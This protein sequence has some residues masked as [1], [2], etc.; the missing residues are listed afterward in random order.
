MTGKDQSVG[1]PKPEPAETD[2]DQDDD[3]PLGMDE[4]V[5][6][7]GVDPAEALRAFMRTPR[8]RAKKR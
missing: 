7:Y 8:H 4:R 6:L 2:D 1:D 5:S 3:E